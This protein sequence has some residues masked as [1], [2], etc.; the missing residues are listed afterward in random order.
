MFLKEYVDIFNNC[1]IVSI[2]S[3]WDWKNIFYVCDIIIVKQVRKC[4]RKA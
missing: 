3:K 4:I 2:V 1:L